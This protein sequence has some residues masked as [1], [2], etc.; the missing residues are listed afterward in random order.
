MERA[1]VRRL[2]RHRSVFL[3]LFCALGA[4]VAVLIAVDAHAWQTTVARD[5]VI[6]TSSRFGAR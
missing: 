5:G 1:A 2:R 3:A 4:V 6:Q